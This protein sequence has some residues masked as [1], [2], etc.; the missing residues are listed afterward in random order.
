MEPRRFRITAEQMKIAI[1]GYGRMGHEIEKAAVSRGHK[2]VCIIDQD[3]TADFDS[4]AFRQ[5]DVA[6]EFTSGATAQ[7]NILKSWEQGV[8]V[9]CGSTGWL[10]AG[11]R[12]WIDE[13]VGGRN[14]LVTASNFSLGV[15]VMF[16]ANRLMARL[17]DGYDNYSV[18]IHEVHHVNKKDHP[19]GTAI[20]L[21][22]DIMAENSRYDG[23]V[24]PEETAPTERDIPITHEREED[25]K[26][27]HVVEWDSPICTLTLRHDAKS[28]DGF[29]I[30]ALVAAEWLASQQTPGHYTMLDV[31]AHIHE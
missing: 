3:N 31:L 26:G 27:I 12:K 4:D 1:I 20:T 8:P 18:N 6:I 22:E 10:N 7:E 16:A 14:R 17:F 11:S 28:R 15:N 25:V 30:G 29:A 2:V 19:S 13:H 24:E 23:W 21:A 5:A 9:V